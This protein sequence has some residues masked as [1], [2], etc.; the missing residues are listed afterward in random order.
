MPKGQRQLSKAYFLIASKTRRCLLLSRP[1]EWEAF[2]KG[3][4]G[5]LFK[6]DLLNVLKK[7]GTELEADGIILAYV[8]R[9]RKGRVTPS[10]LISRHPWPLKSI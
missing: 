7:V 1:I 10:A 9:L 3:S 8:Y 6:A 5:G 4:Q 2:T